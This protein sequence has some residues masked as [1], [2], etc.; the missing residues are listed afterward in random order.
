M[1]VHQ[2]NQKRWSLEVR[3]EKTVT[4]SGATVERKW[5]RGPDRLVELEKKA[6]N[7]RGTWKDNIFL[8]K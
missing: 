8:Q 3:E 1:H 5:H 7:L 4:K 6:L 2:R